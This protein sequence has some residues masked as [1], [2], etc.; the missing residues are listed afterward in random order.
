MTLCPLPL[1]PLL[2]PLLPLLV[3]LVFLF[4]PLHQC[5]QRFKFPLLWLPPQEPCI[6]TSNEG[7]DESWEDD[8]EHICVEKG[9]ELGFPPKIDEPE[10][11]MKAPGKDD[12]LNTHSATQFL[13]RITKALSLT[14]KAGN[15]YGH[16]ETFSQW[17]IVKGFRCHLTPLHS[18]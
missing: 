12:D 9:P 17:C 5:S 18:N 7:G 13:Y 3:P 6:L 14:S 15:R 2:V 16:S 10:Y 11:G 4:H 8:I 1:L